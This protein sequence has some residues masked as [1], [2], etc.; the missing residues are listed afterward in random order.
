MV[1]IDQDPS[2]DQGLSPKIQDKIDLG[3][4]YNITDHKEMSDKMERTIGIVINHNQ[5][6]ELLR[7]L[8]LLFLNVLDVTVDNVTR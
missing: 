4:S 7:L 2:Q 8:L 3:D 5:N 6:K 1:L